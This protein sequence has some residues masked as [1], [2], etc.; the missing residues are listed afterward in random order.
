MRYVLAAFLIFLLSACAPKTTS[1]DPLAGLEHRAGFIDLYVDKGANKV[2]VK[3]PKADEEG[4]SLRLIHTARLTAGLG[5]NPVGLDRGWGDG[6]KIIA[7]RK[8]GNKIIIEAE[9][10]TY[11]ASPNNPR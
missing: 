5:S 6:G 11:R 7:F 10:M 2:L 8:Y 4:V 1:S 3:L 9:N